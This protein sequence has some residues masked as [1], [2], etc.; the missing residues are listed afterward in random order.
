MFSDLH[1]QAMVSFLNNNIGQCLYLE[2]EKSVNISPLLRTII[3]GNVFL[4]IKGLSCTSKTT[5]PW[6]RQDLFLERQ[7]QTRSF[8]KIAIS[9]LFR[10]A[11]SSNVPSKDSNIR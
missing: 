2:R 4:S 3:L 7:Y 5:W 10:G 11:I 6:R 9:G 8:L 1:Y